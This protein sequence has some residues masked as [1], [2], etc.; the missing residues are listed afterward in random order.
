ME[1]REAAG[2]RCLKSPVLEELDFLAHLFSTRDFGNQ[3]LHVGDDPVRVREHRRLFSEA[4][5]VKA[6]DLVSG[7]QVHGTRVLRVGAE[8]LGRGSLDYE[9]GFEGTDGLITDVPGIPLFGFYADCTPI[10]LTDP[11]R[12][13]IG[14]V[15]AGWKGTLSDIAGIAVER[16]AEEFGSR[17][18]DLIAVIAPRIGVECYPVSREVLE[19]AAALGFAGPPYVQGD[20]LDLGAINEALLRRKGVK[21]IETDRHCTACRLDLFYS[22]RREAGKDGHTGRMAAIVMIRN[23]EKE[24]ER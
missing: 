4:A 16:M 20:H 13:A 1:I 12:K 8:D 5:G 23:E 21:R 6:E 14:L 15:H 9:D 17:P 24:G 18:E 22:H 10:F 7:Q 3:G 19:Q 2:R 11:V